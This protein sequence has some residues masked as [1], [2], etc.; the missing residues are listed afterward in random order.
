MS[1][2]NLFVLDHEVDPRASILGFVIMAV[3]E[4]SAVRCN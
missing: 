4:V 1:L 2:Y 3:W